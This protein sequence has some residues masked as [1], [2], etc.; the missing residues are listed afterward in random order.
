MRDKLHRI[1]IQHADIF[2]PMSTHTIGGVAKK[3]TGVLNTKKIPFRTT[4]GF[5]N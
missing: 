2:Q 4:R 5:L 3:F 1:G